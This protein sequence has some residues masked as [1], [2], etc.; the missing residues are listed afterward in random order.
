MST[1]GYHPYEP[2]FQPQGVVDGVWTVDGPE[3][4]YRFAGLTLPCPTRMTIIRTTAGKL[5]LHSPVALNTELLR[6]IGALGDVG[7]IIAP[8]SF[9]YTHMP[10]WAAAFP[11]ATCH[12]SPDIAVKFADALPGVVPLQSGPHPD[13]ADDIDQHLAELGSFTEAV[14]FHRA[15]KTLIVT[16]LVQNFESDRI[17]RPFTRLMLQMGGATGPR[18]TTSMDIRLAARGHHTAVRDA[19][20]QMAAWA[21]ERIIL[22]H[23]KCYHRAVPQE[24]KAAFAWARGR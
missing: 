16:D 22:S 15:S 10:A 19:V 11:A 21:P 14:F 7:W 6:R 2:Q 23:G 9:H 17:R 13:W 4:G 18:G 1:P 20:A 8:N 24:L 3:V 5:W 12:A